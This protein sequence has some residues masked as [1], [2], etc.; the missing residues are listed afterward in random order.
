MQTIVKAADR[1]DFLALVPQLVGYVPTQSLVLVAFRGTRT[2][3]ALRVDLP[4]AAASAA[5]HK[6]I[7]NTS[8]GMLCKIRWAD[9]VVPVVYTDEPCAGADAP[10][11]YPLAEAVARRATLSGFT[12]K[13]ALWVARDGWGT[14]LDSA[15][16]IIDLGAD[17]A[18]GHPARRPLEEIAASTA[19]AQVPDGALSQ[20][21]AP[22]DL[23]RLPQAGFAE[24]ERVATAL[25]R[26]Q[27][28]Q[29]GDE[30]LLIDPVI[31]AERSLT[32]EG[33]A[34]P[35]ACAAI[36]L[37]VV[38]S[39]AGRDQVMLQYAFGQSVGEQALAVN[40]R[41]A[42]MQRGTGASLDDIVAAE[43]SEGRQPADS[44]FIGSLMMGQ[45]TERPDLER[46]QRAI[47]LLKRLVSLA[48]RR[49][50]PAPL[51]MLAW[52]SWSLGR[53]SAAGLF[54]DQALTIDPG[55]GMARLL[56]TMFGT[57]MLPEWAFHPAADQRDDRRVRERQLRA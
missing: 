15:G 55:Y 42:A 51:C 32:W 50:R 43:I 30:S 38:T 25:R 41:Y 21:L 48:P 14:Y 1:A 17:P 6:R 27:Q 47:V 49:S 9:A 23:A 19:L 45:T 31:L 37:L 46:V 44:E 12:L 16:R 52:L 40:D 54:V 28:P 26:L 3:G 34:L 11:R 22:A 10:P 57:G 4:A 53:G 5:V 24:R 13:D 56:L 20:L 18:A 8:F 29:D 7:A 2:C 35:P 36:L 33:D 39:P